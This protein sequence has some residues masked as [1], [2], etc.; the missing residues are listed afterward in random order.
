MICRHSHEQSEKGEGIHVVKNEECEDEQH[1]K[2][3]FTEKRVYLS[4]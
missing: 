1:G 2:G 3:H 4:R